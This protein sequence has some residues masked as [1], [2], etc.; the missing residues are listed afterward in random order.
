MPLI[1]RLFRY[2]VAHIIIPPRI[3]S[4]RK[5]QINLRGNSRTTGDARYLCQSVRFLTLLTAFVRSH[6]SAAST[7][8]MQN[9]LKM[10][11]FPEPPSS[12]Y[13]R[14]T[15]MPVSACPPR[16]ILPCALQMMCAPAQAWTTCCWTWVCSDGRIEPCSRCPLKFA[17]SIAFHKLAAAKD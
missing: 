2:P 1:P 10:I 17:R 11:E 14:K 8:H 15:T 7:R 12:L 9:A 16:Q 13:T 5:F 6:R 3:Q 4:I